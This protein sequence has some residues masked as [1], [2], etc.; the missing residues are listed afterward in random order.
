MLAAACQRCVR[1][2]V[3]PT[4]VFARCGLSIQAPLVKADEPAPAPRKGMTVSRAD[5]T[6]DV[7]IPLGG[8]T[9]G[10]DPPSRASMWQ[11]GPHK[12]PPETWVRDFVTDSRQSIVGLPRLLFDAPARLD[13]VHKAA[14]WQRAAMR[15]GTA[16]TKHRGEVSGSS[17]KVYPQKGRGAAR[18]SDKKAPIFVGGGRAFGPR[19][20][21]WSYRLSPKILLNGLRA[22]LTIKYVQGHVE[23]VENMQLDSVSGRV[24]AEIQQER[25]WKSAFLVDTSLD[26]NMQAAANGMTS[27][28]FQRAEFLNVHDVLKYEKLVITPT[29]LEYVMNEARNIGLDRYAETTEEQSTL[30]NELPQLTFKQNKI[31][32][33]SWKY[34]EGGLRLTRTERGPR[35]TQ[36]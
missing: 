7:P 26:H 10:F 32:I 3:V 29:V 36:L 9:P 5:R 15:A 6:F 4:R 27:I 17:R 16:K 12:P 2:H 24:L 28:N 8:S 30:Y 23:V 14:M 20:K 22:A 31:N 1:T 19:P 13:L 25:A 11:V 33:H 35:K 21:D 34:R 18:H